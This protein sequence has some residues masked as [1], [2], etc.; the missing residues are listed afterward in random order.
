MARTNRV[1]GGGGVVIVMGNQAEPSAFLLFVLGEE[2]D[3]KRLRLYRR[4]NVVNGNKEAQNCVI[5]SG[6][7]E[8]AWLPCDANYSE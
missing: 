1:T 3:V 7:S 8:M 4:D 2:C 5:I 6:N